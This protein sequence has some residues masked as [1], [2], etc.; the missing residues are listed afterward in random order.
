MVKLSEFG[1]KDIPDARMV[2][3]VRDSDGTQFEVQRFHVSSQLP[4]VRGYSYYCVRNEVLFQESKVALTLADV[5][6]TIR[7]A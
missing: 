2:V 3:V 7:K 4:L 6:K 5:R 1:I